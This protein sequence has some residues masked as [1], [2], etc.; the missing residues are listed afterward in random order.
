[1]VQQMQ[2]IRTPE[3]IRMMMVILASVLAL[4]VSSPAKAQFVDTKWQVTG[5]V[6]EAWFAD[7]GK[8]I[9]Q[10]QEFFKGWAQGIF[11]N[12]D[13]AGQS[14]TY[15]AYSPADFLAN[16]EF[17]LFKRAKVSLGDGTVFVHRISCNG[18]DAVGRRVLYPFV[19]QQSTNKAYYLFEGAIYLLA[20]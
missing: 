11:Y 16:P 7:T 5:F 15:T 9:G 8:I 10:T 2:R 19:T 13:Y 14:M 3:R 1:M 20:Y 17:D 18:K 12:C 6:G 4:A